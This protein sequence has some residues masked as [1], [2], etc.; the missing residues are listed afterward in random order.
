MSP[1]GVILAGHGCAPPCGLPASP[2]AGQAANTGCLHFRQMC[3]TKM[4]AGSDDRLGASS[5]PH[6]EQEA[7]VSSPGPWLSDTEVFLLA[8]GLGASGPVGR[9]VSRVWMLTAPTSVLGN[10]C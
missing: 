10:R 9:Q 7:L 4:S 3:N 1:L 6:A 5:I 2:A 8:A